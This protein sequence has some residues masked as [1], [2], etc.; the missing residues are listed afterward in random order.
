MFEATVVE[1]R[2]YSWLERRVEGLDLRTDTLDM[3]ICL[4][5]PSLV[6]STVAPESL[7]ECWRSSGD[8]FRWS[9]FRGGTRATPR[10]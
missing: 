8:S 3:H 4:G 1:D 5:T 7:F 9:S 2:A 10:V 6:S